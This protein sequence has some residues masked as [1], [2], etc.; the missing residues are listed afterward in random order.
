MDEHVDM[1]CVGKGEKPILNLLCRLDKT[2][3][4]TDTQ[5]LWVKKNGTLYKNKP[6]DLLKSDEIPMPDI[7][8]Y[9][10]FPNILKSNGIT[11]M[12][13]RG[14]PFSCFFCANYMNNKV[15]GS[16]FFRIR[17]IDD[18]IEEIELAK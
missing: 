10:E 1:T 13:S 6:G 17:R 11:V 16:D 8:I 18:I 7:S 15:Y 12:C 9:N 3:N 14:C 2:E 5:S 4:Y